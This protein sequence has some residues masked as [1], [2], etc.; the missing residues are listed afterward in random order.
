MFYFVWHR[1]DGQE[2]I[3]REE[4]ASLHGIDDDGFGGRAVGWDGMGR[5]FLLSELF[6]R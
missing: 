3:T 2:G 4:P 1:Q 6:T 5:G